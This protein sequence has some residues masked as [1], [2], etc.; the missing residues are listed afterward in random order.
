[1]RENGWQANA[2]VTA[3]ND[4]R[5]VT[6]TKASSKMIKCTVKEISRGET[7][8]STKASSLTIKERARENTYGKMDAFTPACGIIT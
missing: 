1:M 7:V 5:T 4:M 6:S 2:T 8:Q 3:K